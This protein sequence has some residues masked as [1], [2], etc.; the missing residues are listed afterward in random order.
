MPL[1]FNFHEFINAS[2]S[3]SRG[4]SQAHGG[5]AGHKSNL[6]LRADIGRKLFEE[7]QTRHTH[8]H[9]LQ[10]V[11][12]PAMGGPGNR[13]EDYALSAGIDLVQS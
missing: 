1:D 13:Q 9:S 12:A 7:E 11:A 4:P 2:P 5:E 10:S 8:I 6:G 3:P